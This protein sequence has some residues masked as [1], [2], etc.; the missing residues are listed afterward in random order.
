MQWEYKRVTGKYVPP[1]PARE[2]V[3]GSMEGGL[4]RIPLSAKPEKDDIMPVLQ[5][6]G[7]FGWELVGV[8][9]VAEQSYHFYL[10][11]PLS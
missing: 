9:Q 1:V 3:M 7:L 5:D 8:L 11:R 6:L 2:T 4:T 10:K